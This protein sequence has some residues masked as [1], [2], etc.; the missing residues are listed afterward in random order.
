MNRQILNSRTLTTACAIVFL[1]FCLWQL[2][3]TKRFF[4][5]ET[6]IFEPPKSTTTNQGYGAGSAKPA[7]Q[8]PS[9]PKINDSKPPTPTTTRVSTTPSAKPPPKVHT[10]RQG[11][12]KKIWHKH[13]P[14]GINEE[15]MKWVKSW[16]ERNPSYR[17]EILSDATSDTFVLENFADRPDILYVY[18]T[19]TVPI[20]RADLVRYL[21]LYAQGGLWA[22]LDAECL[23]PID[24]WIPREFQDKEINM[25]VGMEFDFGWRNDGF[26][27]DQF[28]S[29]SL[30]AKPGTKHLEVIIND[31]LA[32]IRKEA[33]DHNVELRDFKMEMVSDVVDVTGPKAMTNAIIKSLSAQLGEQLDDR[34]ISSTKL[35]KPTLLGD[36]LILPGG[37]MAALQNGMPKDEGEYLVSHHYSGSWK[38]K[39][40]GETVEEKKEEKKPEEKKEEE[41]KPEEKKEEEKKPEEKKEEK[42]PEEKKEE[43]KKQ[44]N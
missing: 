21:I 34:N 32:R 41:K 20:L 27:H 15:T 16:T 22:D 24:N 29:W 18:Y 28:N 30:M 31:A 19:L 4:D 2:S 44:G 9:A 33:A 17:Q 23:V 40:G 11:F 7:A 3:S 38:N 26:F 39:D 36:V 10:N 35:K 14:K 1:T 43:E 6:I 8:P 12:P 42:K 37:A 13:G 5:S 25:V